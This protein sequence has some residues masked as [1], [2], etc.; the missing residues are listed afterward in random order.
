MRTKQIL[1]PEGLFLVSDFQLKNTWSTNLWQKPLMTLMHFFFRVFANLNSSNLKHIKKE[2]AL[3]EFQINRE[4][5]YFGSIIFSAV[6]SYK[7][8]ITI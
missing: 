2:V 6:Y 5:H 8:K 1:K 3:A 7:E 4:K